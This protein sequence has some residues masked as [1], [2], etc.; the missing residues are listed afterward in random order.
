MLRYIGNDRHRFPVFVANHVQLIREFSVPDQWK[1]V[2]SDFNP[3]DEASRGI[4]SEN[5]NTT[6]KWL[7]GSDFLYSEESVWPTIQIS[8]IDEGESS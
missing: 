1:Y 2:P 6:A 7:E 8:L 4:S 3:A 5:L